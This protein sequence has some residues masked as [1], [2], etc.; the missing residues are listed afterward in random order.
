MRLRGW[1]VERFGGLVDH[2]YR[3]PEG[4]G[5]LL[6][7]HGPNEA[8]KSTLL[9]FINAML[10]GAP[11]PGAGRLL[12][13]HGGRR[14]VLRRNLEARRGGFSL[15]GEDGRELGPDGLAALL[16]GVDA[17]VYKAVFAFGLNELAE[18]AS[19]TAEGVQER[20]LSAGISG[21]GASARA[22]LNAVRAETDALLRP[23]A[24]SAL[25]DAAG[26]YLRLRDDLR[27]LQADAA[28]YAGLLEAEGRLGEEVRDLDGRLADAAA[29]ARRLEV[30]LQAWPS[31]CE[32][33]DAARHLEAYAGPRELPPVSEAQ[34]E[35]ARAEEGR[36]EGAVRALES[37]CE[38][39]GETAAR[40]A[41]QVD[42]TLLAAAGPLRAASGELPLQRSRQ[43]ETADGEAA[44]AGARQELARRLADLG[45]GWDA[46]RLARLDRSLERQAEAR[47]FAEATATLGGKRLAA[48]N[49]AG[50]ARAAL[51]RARERA[52]SA[53]PPDGRLLPL[54][55]ELR[56]LHDNAALQRNRLAEL[57]RRA[58]ERERLER[59]L[60]GLAPAATAPG[61]ASR[62]ERERAVARLR[63]RLPALAAAGAATKP[64]LP[65]WAWLLPLLPLALGG[66]LLA[67]GQA[68]AG[69]AAVAAALLTL[70]AV[71]A[72]GR[73]L[74]APAAGIADGDLA[75]G[76][77]QDLTLLGLPAG[78]DIG[79]VE[80]AALALTAARAS[81]CRRRS[82]VRASAAGTTRHARPPPP[83]RTP[84]PRP[85]AWRLPPAPGKTGPWT[86]CGRR[87]ARAARGPPGR[88]SGA[89]NWS[90]PWS[91]PTSPRR[92]PWRGRPRRGP[93]KPPS[94]RRAP[95]WP[96][97]R[98]S[99]PAWT[100][101]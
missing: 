10:F 44:L 39:Q 51:E 75:A 34:L 9:R 29:R 70:A 45:P 64:R 38:R 91:A 28:A 85:P 32:R 16:G 3:L 18:L 5:G 7:V 4:A 55:P 100:S 88:A 98:A 94:R 79:R 77:R 68:P 41:G 66:W 92:K 33:R 35:F 61:A 27:R 69:A 54:E 63:G 25:G 101:S 95:R 31:W 2:R 89:R 36:L 82:A 21:A 49:R 11:G 12:L 42:G 22:G 24:S 93:R 19:L 14:L 97:P 59:A 65:L 80:E 73:S 58:V 99:S 53:A 47:Q 83:S 20:I 30:T 52:A 84:A 71:A 13:E 46:G 56:A 78:A 1:D 26:E 74:A 48:A 96:A 67:S 72:L 8:G 37:A 23:R 17:R 76:I 57:E 50:D 40:L 15:L 62:D 6:V 60:A 86:R 90:P 43:R 87:P 81:S